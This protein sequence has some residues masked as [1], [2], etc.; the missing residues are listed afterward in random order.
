[1][2]TPQ[3]LWTVFRKSHKNTIFRTK[4]QSKQPT[5]LTISAGFIQTFSNRKQSKPWSVPSEEKNYTF[6]FSWNKQKTTLLKHLFVIMKTIE[7]ISIFCCIL[8]LLK[9]W[10]QLRSGELTE[11]FRKLYQNT[12]FNWSKCRGTIFK[13]LF[14]KAS[15]KIYQITTT[16]TETNLTFLGTKR[17]EYKCKLRKD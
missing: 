10:M 2:E 14:K 11:I 6:I 5:M 12:L 1:M 17:K 3:R 15:W 7:L 8:V 9:F 13:L 16:T 4:F